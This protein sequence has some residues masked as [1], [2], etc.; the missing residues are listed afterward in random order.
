M[1]RSIIVG[2]VHG[3][4]EELARLLE[5]VE[6]AGDDQLYL[7]GDLV[8]RGP[9]PRG[10]LALARQHRATS[11]RGN[12][13][14]RLLRWRELRGAPPKTDDLTPL[15]RK[16]MKS[17]GL[18][19]TA[20]LLDDDDWA[21]LEAM[22]LWLRLPEHEAA[23]VHAG[24]LPGIPLAEQKPR[25]L[26]YLRALDDDG[27]PLEER[28]RGTPWGERYRG[29]PHIVFGHYARHEPQLHPWA[30]GIDT[31]CVYGGRLTALVLGPGPPPTVAERAESLVSI[32]ALRSYYP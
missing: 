4:A 2:D 1:S 16:V 10:V 20:A 8:M 32:P 22:P 24:V 13:E 30:T 9:D 6:L 12:H 5:R 7:V 21:Y 15:D 14:H 25:H 3:C 17:K 19:R 29:P 28:E 23:I 31:G 18:R 27:A 11:V 26:M